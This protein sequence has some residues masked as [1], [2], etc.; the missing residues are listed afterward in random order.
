MMGIVDAGACGV[1]SYLQAQTA[2][3]ECLPCIEG[4]AAEA[5]Q[6]GCCTVAQN[7]TSDCFTLVVCMEACSSGDEVCLSTCENKASSAAVAIY[8]DL[9]NCLANT[10]LT[11]CPGLPLPMPGD[12]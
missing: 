1:A 6:L 7:C 10:C 4:E 9:S 2:N 3:L 8:T 12:L 11:Q 5:S